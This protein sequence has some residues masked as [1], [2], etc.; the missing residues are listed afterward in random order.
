MA[1]VAVLRRF[2]DE[3]GFEQKLVAL[4]HLLLV[5]CGS[6]AGEGD[7]QALGSIECLTRHARLA[8]G[9]SGPRLEVGLDDLRQASGLAA[10]P[11]LPREIRIPAAPHRSV[12]VVTLRRTDGSQIAHGNDRWIGCHLPV[13][14]PVAVNQR[15]DLPGMPQLDAGLL[16]DPEAQARLERLVL[17]GRERTAGKGAVA[18]PLAAR[19]RHHGDHRLV[20][21]HGEDRR[22]ETDT[23]RLGCPRGRHPCREH[24]L[25]VVRRR[26]HEKP[27][28]KSRH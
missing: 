26:V 23:D 15:A 13:I 4:E 18:L 24:A 10:A 17:A 16:A 3:T 12:L 7:A 9:G 5:P 28:S 6:V 22:V 11:V 25:H 20:A 8:M 1:A 21:A 19:G 27:R 2:A 14:G